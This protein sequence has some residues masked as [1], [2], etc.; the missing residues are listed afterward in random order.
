MN[1]RN[2]AFTLIELLVVISI[3]ALLVSILLPAL[4]SARKTAVQLQCMSQHKSVGAAVHMYQTDNNGYFPFRSD[5][6]A[7]TPDGGDQWRWWYSMAPYLGYEPTRADMLAFDG[8]FCPT[9]EDRPADW[10]AQQSPGAMIGQNINIMPIML[11]NGTTLSP[12]HNPSHPNLQIR[13]VH[14]DT[15]SEIVLHFDMRRPLAWT[16]PSSLNIYGNT[17]AIAPHF[18]NTDWTVYGPVGPGLIGVGFVDGHAGAHHRD[19]FSTSAGW[20][21]YRISNP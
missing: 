9:A 8:W 14:I 4:G 15:P 5:Q 12:Y 19:D 7:S 2:S 21:G 1:H 6:R 17:E 16:Q 10:T 20:D 3:I 18:S 11:A 13:D